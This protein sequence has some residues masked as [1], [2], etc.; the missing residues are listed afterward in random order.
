MYKY[1][2]ISVV[3]KNV[4]VRQKSKDASRISVDKK[5]SGDLVE[6]G[7]DG[8]DGEGGNYYVLFI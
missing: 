4:N 1:I 7:G 8:D 5:I 3:G 6:E 2:G